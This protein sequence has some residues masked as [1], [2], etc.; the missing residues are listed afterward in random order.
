MKVFIRSDE[1]AS[2][3]PIVIGMY[4]DDSNIADDAHGS[5]ISV[6][7]VPDGLVERTRG[8]PLRLAANW[9]ERVGSSPVAAEAKRRIEDAFSLADQVQS[10]HDLIEAIVSHGPDMSKW[11]ADVRQHKQALD[12]KWKYV[13]AVRA[14]ANEHSKALPRDPSNDKAWPQRLV[15]KA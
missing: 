3:K 8:E 12:E 4:P 6:V 1:I 2:E 15:K 14:K 9:R 10:L 5:G 7:S 11:P 13:G